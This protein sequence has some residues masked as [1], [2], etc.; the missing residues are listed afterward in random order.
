MKIW[1]ENDEYKMAFIEVRKNEESIVADFNSES[2]GTTIIL[3]DAGVNAFYKVYHA[4]LNFLEDEVDEDLSCVF[5]P[6][7]TEW[8]YE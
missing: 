5:E 2:I 7:E 8:Y 3:T 1:V 4:I 6:N